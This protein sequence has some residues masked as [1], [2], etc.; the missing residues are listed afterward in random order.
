[1]DVRTFAKNIDLNEESELHIQ[2]KTDS[3]DTLNRCRTQRWRLRALRS[4][5][6]ATAW[7]LR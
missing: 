5:L 2:K 6:K 1:M 7:S 4:E 3:R